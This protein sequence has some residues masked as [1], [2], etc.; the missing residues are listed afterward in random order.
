MGAADQEG[1][2]GGGHMGGEGEETGQ[3]RRQGEDRGQG[4]GQGEGRGEG[5]ERGQGEEGSDQGRGQG[6]GGGQG[7]GQGE[8]RAESQG[9]PHQYDSND[10]IQ[11]NGESQYELETEP[12]WIPRTKFRKEQN[13]MR[14]QRVSVV[15][16]Y[17]NI[18]LTKSMESVLNRG[19]NFC[20]LPL[21]LDITQ[22]LV[23]FSRFERTM[24][25]HSGMVK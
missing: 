23:E 5:E 24:R 2:E 9:G 20:I 4:G 12:K 14:K 3:E 10:P 21:N 8:G 17:S 18:T 7:G 6:T 13:R 25:W 19:L 16:N 15:F 22:V 1:G 11:T